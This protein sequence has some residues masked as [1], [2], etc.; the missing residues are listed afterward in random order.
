[1]TAT[2]VPTARKITDLTGPGHTDRFGIGGTDL[3]ATTTA[4]DGRLVSVFGDTFERATV[5]GRGWR[6]PVILFGD[7]ASVAT[8]IEW[9]GS[10]GEGDY[11][12]Q[13]CDYR[14]NR[15]VD[16]CRVVT[17][18]P[19][20][21]I[22]IG[23]TLYLHVMVCRELGTVHWTE[24][25]SSRDNGV[26]WE[27]T[28]ARWPGD[29]LGGLFQM[30]TWEIGGDGYVYAFTTGFQRAHGLIQHRVPEHAVTDPAAW[31]SWGFSDGSWGWG[32][33]PTITLPGRFGELSLRRVEGQLLLAAFDDGN[34]R[35]DVF[36]LDSFTADMHVA[37]RATVLH[38]CLWEDEDHDAGRVAQLYGGY[39]V[40]GSTLA[41]LNL[42][43]SQWNT[44]TN[45][46]YHAM[47]FRTDVSALAGSQT[48]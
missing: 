30:L 47:Q 41:E 5:G 13:V 43:V 37:P 31:E 35:M 33:P 8:G 9:T 10:A 16:G 1:M 15:W 29:H 11:A 32:R 19:T 23:D 44:A 22:R 25:H 27:V 2:N 45:W 48:P 17:K 38:G 28:D 7:P 14:H 12:H 46:P 18:L 6:S 39:I 36:A 20:D 3:G 24:L 26:T 42:I 34:Y 4:P 21:V 40:P